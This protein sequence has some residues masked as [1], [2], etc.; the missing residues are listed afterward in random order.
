[1]EPEAADSIQPGPEFDLSPR[2]RLLFDFDWKF[3]QGHA[4]DSALDLGFGDCHYGQDL[5]TTGDLKFALATFNDETWR[6][7][8]L[9]HDWGVELPFVFDKELPSPYGQEARGFKPLGRE[10]PETSIGW[11]RRVFD[12]PESDLGRRIFV[13]FDGVFQSAL[14]FCNGSFV[15]RSNS[16]CVPFRLDLTPFLFYGKRNCITVRVDGSL[17]E[18]WYYEGAGIYRHVWLTKV[19]MFHLG[20]LET[21][22]RTVVRE[23]AAYLN[24]SALVENETLEKQRC[25]IRWRILDAAG[26][27]VA[28]AASSIAE[29]AAGC[30]HGL[31][32]EATIRGPKLWSPQTP[33]LYSAIV[34]LEAAGDVRDMDQVTFGIRTL[35]FD[36]NQGFFLNGKKLP[37]Q[38]TCNHQ[39][40]AG[41][42]VALP[43]RLQYYRL[44]VLTSAGC[45]AVRTAHH[46][47][48]P[49]WVRA[50]E[51]SGVLMICETRS[52]S[53]S[54]EGLAQLEAMIKRYRNSPS[55]FLWSLGNEEVTLQSNEVGSRVIREMQEHAHRLDPSR[56]CTAAVLGVPL[57]RSFA[58]ELDVMGFNHNLT[59]PD[60]YHKAHPMQPSIGTETASTTSTRGIYTTDKSK[61]WMSAY[62]ANAGAE[63]AD[64]YLAFFASRP[65]LSGSFIW[66]GFDYRGEPTPYSWPSISSQF[67]IVD[68][69]GF[70]KDNFYYYKAWWSNE[71]LLH[72]FPHWNWPGKEGEDI[73]VWVHSNVEC[74]ELL[75]NGQS[76][77]AK[78]VVPFRHLEWRVKYEPGIL[79]ARGMR[80][81]KVVL[82]A[83]HE[84]TG[85][86]VKVVL[87]SDRAQINADG[88][89]LAVLKAET[90]DR[91]GRRVPTANNLIR[92][93]VL[94]GGSLIGVGNGDP[95]CHESDKG[96]ERS[97]F[98][99]LAQAIIQSSR[100]PGSITIRAT[101]EGLEGATFVIETRQVKLRKA[102]A[103]VLI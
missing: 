35:A 45:N 38:G 97:L 33:N 73:L 88:E 51:Q 16:G 57:E 74:V 96:T 49:E 28:T 103:S 5:S 81:G 75:C 41:V 25:I 47:P 14:V 84:T 85:N 77:G 24:L 91:N 86:P 37:V 6:S 70:P 30:K 26:Q 50:C 92:F 18:G 65:W 63:R 67:G 46:M 101:S 7:V 52:M 99:G 34:A 79:E 42:G 44:G 1:V 4:T 94:G 100:N 87:T 22:V 27:I 64:D 71:P 23:D 60:Q 61:N 76:L 40:H 83:Q 2:E 72:L 80:D 10:F 31:S 55:I 54:E 21:V 53:S 3:T 93:K 95:N 20:H 9:P 43:D 32:A 15:G 66:T 11:Y 98:S 68:T 78:K 102:V 89:D 62:D 69:C 56:F 58:P 90:I 12:I 59:D 36:A 8:N 48:T 39:D 29:V 82:T 13:D 17:S 19:D